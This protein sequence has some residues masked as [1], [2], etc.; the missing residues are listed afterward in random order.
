MEKIT[1]I[2]NIAK[3]FFAIIKESDFDYGF[4]VG[5]VFAIGILLLFIIIKLIARSIFKLRK[6]KKIVVTPKDNRGD[7]T[8]MVS[9]IE[10]AVREEIAQLHNVTVEKIK[11][12]QRRSAYYLTVKCSYDGKSGSLVEVR[13]AINTRLE[14]VFK[15]FFGVENLKQINLTFCEIELPEFPDKQNEE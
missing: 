12:Y 7:I 6:V 2:I 13:D 3:E 15:E 14:I 8:I 9:A 5:V 10:H 11:I 4:T 1:E